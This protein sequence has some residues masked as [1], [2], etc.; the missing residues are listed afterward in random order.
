MQYFAVKKINLYDVLFY[1]Y[2]QTDDIRP[3][4]EVHINVKLLKN[5]AF[6]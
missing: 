2:R 4:D 5:R 6:R 3:K 1:A